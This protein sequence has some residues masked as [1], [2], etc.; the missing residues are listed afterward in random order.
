MP[1]YIIEHL[2]PKLWK[3][4]RIEYKHIS[5]IV[6]KDNIWITKLKWGNKEL[7]N[8]G[9]VIKNSI[10]ELELNNACV[11]DPE[12]EKLLAPKEAK[13]FD[14]FVF[15]GILGDYPPKKRTEIELSPKLLPN[16]E[17]RNLG[18]EQM[19][20][21]N[22]IYVTKQIVD[23]TSLEKIKFQDEMEIEKEE[24]ISIQL[25]YR[26]ALVDGKPL[27]SEELLDYLKKKK[28]F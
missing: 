13:K 24:G 19:S 26:Y 21:D 6:G 12:A 7:S 20:T 27:I 18:K 28:G 4:C 17:R 3:W 16:A 10:S 8:Y 1:I 14:Y 15:G 25:P 11:L 22:A 2:E 23:G 5:K 9:K